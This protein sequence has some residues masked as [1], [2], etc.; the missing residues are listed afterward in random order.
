[1]PTYR[2]RFLSETTIELKH[3]LEFSFPENVKVIVCDRIE[4]DEQGVPMKFGF[5][6]DA[7]CQSDDAEQAIKATRA[8]VD[9][10]VGMI[11]FS[12]SAVASLCTPTVVLD[13]TPGIPQRELLQYIQLELRIRPSRTFRE[14]AFS[15]LWKNIEALTLEDRTRIY[16]AARWY[17]KALLEDDSFDQ[18]MNLW[19][20]LE[21]INELM[22]RKYGLPEEKPIR[23]CPRCGEPVLLEPTLA[24]ID[25]LLI[26]LLKVPRETWRQIVKVRTSLYHGFGELGKLV[27]EMPELIPILRT[28]LLKGILDLVDIPSES[29]HGLIREP[30]RHVPRPYA[31]V[32]AVLHDVPVQDILSGKVDPQFQIDNVETTT[33]LDKDGTKH[34]QSKI[35]LK[36]HGFQG[37]WSRKYVEIFAGRDPEDV[38]ASIS[39]SIE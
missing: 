11:S 16:R 4:R 31:R 1:M 26:N 3:P 20:G 5:M 2:V 30:L 14:D 21:V 18:F 24:G 29:Q 35:N 37:T 15:I 39:L 28:G 36:L 13:V 25:Y 12:V 38:S 34:E 33:S 17:R 27:E 9:G 19:T 8:L 6:L 22:K 23:N 7:T 10:I 32:C